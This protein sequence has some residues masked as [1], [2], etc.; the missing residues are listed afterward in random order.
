MLTLGRLLLFETANLAEQDYLTL[1][2]CHTQNP[3]I[4]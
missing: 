1:A 3:R 2:T 4:N